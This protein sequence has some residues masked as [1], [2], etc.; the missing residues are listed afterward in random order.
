M[1]TVN[2]PKIWQEAT[3]NLYEGRPRSRVPDLP[4]VGQNFQVCT[5]KKEEAAIALAY[6]AVV[7]RETPEKLV[8]MRALASALTVLFDDASNFLGSPQ[9]PDTL[10][11][12]GIFM[13]DDVTATT[14][15]RT[16]FEDA[17]VLTMADVEPYLDCDTSELG[18]YFGNVFYAGTKRLTPQ[19]ASAFNEKRLNTVLSTSAKALKI[20]VPGS[21]FMDERVLNKIYASFQAF[22][23]L[24]CQMIHRTCLKTGVI[25]YGP[26]VT[27]TAMFLL[28]VDNG[29]GTLKVI[30]E[31]ALK[32]NWLLTDFPELRP[33]LEAADRA[34]QVLRAVDA[35]VRPFVKAI[36]G[37]AWVPI[38]QNEVS[39]LLG[40]SKKV[41][42]HFTPSYARF[43]GGFTTAGQDAI[44]AMRLG[45]AVEQVGHEE[46]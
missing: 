35:P 7:I 36:Y 46:I 18:G 42:T 21:G 45:I 40:V 8:V 38:A 1:E 26:V 28:L 20:F 9:A 44:I 6:F 27:F 25:R 41:M 4:A 31:A 15:I 23:A 30:K 29:L 3:T 2:N 11:G 34:Q 24:R 37:S 33:E 19:N 12:L 43:G 22:A 14:E 16:N 10:E 39:N 13:N 5:A 17:P 32:C